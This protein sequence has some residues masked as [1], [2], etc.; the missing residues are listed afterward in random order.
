MADVHQPILMPTS[1]NAPKLV[2]LVTMP[3]STIPIFKSLISWT[4]SWKLKASNFSRGSRPGFSNSVRISVSVGRPTCALTYFSN[5]TAFRAPRWSSNPLRCNSNLSRTALP[6]HNARG[7]QHWCRA[8]SCYRG[9]AKTCAL[10]K[11]LL[12]QARHFLQSCPTFERLH[13]DCDIQQYFFANCSPI[14]KH[15]STT[16]CW[17]C[18]PLPPQSLHNSLPHHLNP[19]FN[20]VWSTS[21]WYCPTPIDFGSILTSSANGS[22]KRLPMDTA[23]RT[24]TS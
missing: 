2:T 19:L 4:P 24:V 13:V 10:F 5:P 20:F 11:G 18:S 1:T 8:N 3:G 15:N 23:P 21:C 14:L 7:A 16:L 9:Y 22:V 12:T 6:T 17:P